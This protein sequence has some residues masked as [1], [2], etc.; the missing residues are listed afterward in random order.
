MSHR[1]HIDFRLSH[2]THR[3]MRTHTPS[4]VPHSIAFPGVPSRGFIFL[5]PILLGWSPKAPWLGR[6]DP[7]LKGPFQGNKLRWTRNI[8]QGPGPGA[9]QVF[10]GWGW[11]G[12]SRG[13]W[14]CVAGGARG[15]S[16][17]RSVPGEKEAFQGEISKGSFSWVGWWRQVSVC[18]HECGV[19]IGSYYDKW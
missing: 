1:C 19:L 16:G 18:N 5:R 9:L 6:W 15:N 10:E 4:V 11:G 8:T 14:G 13:E 3:H 12:I 2:R 17:G 7:C